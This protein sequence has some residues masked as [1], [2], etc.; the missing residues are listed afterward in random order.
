MALQGSVENRYRPLQGIEVR[1]DFRDVHLDILKKYIRDYPLQKSK[2]CLICGKF[3]DGRGKLYMTNT[4]LRQHLVNHHGNLM[5]QEVSS[6]NGAS[7]EYSRKRS[8][9]VAS[10]V[11]PAIKGLDVENL[12][13]HSDDNITDE[14][15][16]KCNLCPKSYKLKHHLKQHTE[17]AHGVSPTN[18]NRIRQDGLNI[19]DSS[20]MDTSNGNLASEAAIKLMKST[21]EN[22]LA[23]TIE[24]LFKSAFNNT[25]PKSDRN[26]PIASPNPMSPPSK[27]A[28]LETEE[29]NS[30]LASSNIPTS[31]ATQ[32]S[33]SLGIKVPDQ[34]MSIKLET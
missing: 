3:W 11:Y 27:M 18:A 10:S 16:W 28:R 33:E 2:E 7:L 29:M 23:S 31:L 20:L 26:S 21:S 15:P 9:P 4:R 17:T 24:N 8:S 12:G 22:G 30:L 34:D 5:Q 25:E 13:Y 6:L 32:I 1:M 14:R 19:S